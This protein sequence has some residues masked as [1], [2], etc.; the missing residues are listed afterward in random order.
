MNTNKMYS[1]IIHNQRQ[2]TKCVTELLKGMKNGK[3]SK[4]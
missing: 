2:N 3:T 4:I 1:L